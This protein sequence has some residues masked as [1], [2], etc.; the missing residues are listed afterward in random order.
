MSDYSLIFGANMARTI[1]K[2]K[3]VVNSA[4]AL[5][6]K[7]GIKA[8]TTRDIALRAGISEGTIYRHFTSK[9]ELACIVF[10]QN[11]EI[12]WKFLR[13]YLHNSK[14]AQEM[15]C[16]YI[17]GYFEFARRHQ[18]RYGF[19]IAAHQTELRKLSREKMKPM[20][21]LI[22]ILRFGQ[23]QGFFRES[24]LCLTA[25]MIFGTLTQTVFYLKSGQIA[26]NYQQVV[27][28]TT[29]ACLRIVKNEPC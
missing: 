2:K 5:F 17:Q 11:L 23:S 7:N 12:F 3:D 18:R 10:E 8:T 27:R 9:D 22:K 28:E 24:N 26:V 13:Q 19:V 1:T 14:N 25:A 6:M 16:A 21:M 4:L 15:L 29:E 20:R